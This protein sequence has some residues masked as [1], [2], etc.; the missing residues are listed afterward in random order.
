MS[1]V[2]Q[3]GVV[4]GN[5]VS[6][7]WELYLLGCECWLELWECWLC[8]GSEGSLLLLL[9]VCWEEAAPGQLSLASP[10]CWPTPHRLGVGLSKNYTGYC[11]TPAHM[12]NVHTTTVTI[13]HGHHPLTPLSPPQTSNSYT[14]NR[15]QLQ[16]VDLQVKAV[17]GRG[18]VCNSRITVR[19]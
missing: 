14:V 11:N 12:Y 5:F 7:D 16:H 3:L 1:C 10:A 19:S 6:P 8:E 9:S 2:Y 13:S 4:S 18:F 15:L 17:V